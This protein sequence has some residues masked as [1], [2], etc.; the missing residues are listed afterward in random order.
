MQEYFL[1]D[2]DYFNEKYFTK[3]PLE[4]VF[5][6]FK[7][8]HLVAKRDI[9]QG[10]LILEADPYVYTVNEEDK[11]KVCDYC[12]NP[13]RKEEAHQDKEIEER[14]MRRKNQEYDDDVDEME[15][16]YNE[17][18]EESEDE[19]LVKKKKKFGL[20]N[21]DFIGKNTLPAH[22]KIENHRHACGNC[23]DSF[24]CSEDCKAKHAQVHALECGTMRRFLSEKRPL[25]L[26]KNPDALSSIRFM[27]RVLAR[28]RMQMRSSSSSEL[29]NKL[30][31]GIGIGFDGMFHAHSP[32]QPLV[33]FD[34]QDILRLYSHRLTTP[35]KKERTRFWST[36]FINKIAEKELIKDVK[37]ED[38]LELFARE[39]CNVFG[40]APPPLIESNSGNQGNKLVTID[41][42]NSVAFGVYPTASYM[43]HSCTP[44]ADIWQIGL[45]LHFQSLKPIAKGEEVNF[46]YIDLATTSERRKSNL[47]GTFMFECKC[48]EEQ[49]EAAASG[50][51]NKKKNTKNC[52]KS[53]LDQFICCACREGLMVPSSLKTESGEN[54]ASISFL[55]EK[56]KAGKE[57]ETRACL[58]CGTIENWD[59]Q[60]KRRIIRNKLDYLH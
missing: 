41:R 21:A 55:D 59:A 17:E 37:D 52:N 35:P 58:Y 38:I 48:K 10:E 42:R 4:L 34:H 9:R 49:E 22:R 5:D 2:L 51:S 13:I 50:E 43:N 40:I 20:T 46:S 18:Y 44:N 53:F 36:L 57:G 8:R 3:T 25:R 27:I 45:R 23:G 54:Y 60:G 30:F 32:H 26:V 12:L 31:G 24:Y 19:E 56:I 1:R 39:Q 7:G 14:R 28:R 47:R 6:S 16:Q 33:H 11:G 15:D 29:A